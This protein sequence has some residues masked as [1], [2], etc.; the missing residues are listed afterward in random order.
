MMVP[1]AFLHTPIP[2]RSPDRRDERTARPSPRSQ[3]QSSWAGRNLPPPRAPQRTTSDPVQPTSAVP[4][5]IPPRKSPHV[6]SRLRPSLPDPPRALSTPLIARVSEQA[7]GATEDG[8]KSL[9]AATAIPPRRTN[10]ARRVQRLPD[11]DHVA[12][13]SKLL[14]E[15]VQVPGDGIMSGSLGNSQFDGLFGQINELVE[16]QM[17][18]GND[19]VD[20]SLLSVRSISSESMPSLADESSGTSVNELKSLSPPAKRSTSDRKAR[21]FSSSEDCGADHPLLHTEHVFSFNPSPSQPLNIITVPTSGRRPAPIK[22]RKSTFSSN[23]TASLRALKSAAQTVSALATTPPILQPDDFLSRSIFSIAPELTDDKRP[24]PSDE[25]PSA[26]LR[27]YLNRPPVPTDSPAEFHFW[28]E[29]PSSTLLSNSK[30]KGR[31][32]GDPFLLPPA[33]ASIPLQTCI[34]SSVRSPTASSPPVWLTADGTP[35]NR[36]TAESLSLGSTL[37]RQREP[38]ENSDFLRILVAEI[39]MRR[40]GKFSEDMESHACMWL[41]ARKSSGKPEQARRDRWTAHFPT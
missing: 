32:K 14:L 37:A 21:L 20:E 35:T 41:P 12:D 24:P 25:L 3:V 30:R 22:A 9:L 28:H 31:K 40:S 18:V 33:P 39:N 34:P 13:F 15:D 1:R 16:G 8:V 19:E 17:I 11:C 5:K 23:L 4:V 6:G 27:R 10:R 38:R 26:A 2:S 36:N 7:E 29:H